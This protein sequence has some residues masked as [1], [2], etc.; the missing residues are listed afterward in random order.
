MKKLRLSLLSALWLLF[1]LALGGAADTPPPPAPA[2]ASAESPAPALPPTKDEAAAVDEGEA[3]PAAEAAPAEAPAPRPKPGKLH[4]TRDHGRQRHSGSERVS[5]FDNSTLAAGEKADVVVSV[6][7]SSTSAGEVGDAVVSVFGSSTS[8]GQVGDA[9]VS[10]LGHTRVTGGS[11]GDAAVSVLGNTYVNGHVGGEVVAVL[12]DIELGPDAVVE[13]NLVCIGG[14]VQRAPTAVVRGEVQR[15]ALGGH[16]F[17]FT[18]L[19]TWFNECLLYGRPLAFDVHLVWAWCIAFAFLGLYALVALI[20]PGGVAKCVQ[21]LEERPGRSLLAALLAMLLTPVAFLL[22]LLTLAIGIGIVLIPLFA[23]GLFFAGLFGKVVM[24]AWLGRRLTKLFGDG[25]L[26]QPFF[27]VLVGGAIMLLLYTVPVLGFVVYKLIGVLGLGV[28]VYTLLLSYQS[29]R[30]PAP[31]KPLTPPA[32][33]VPPVLGVAAGAAV[34][35]DGSAA[36][37]TAAPSVAAAAGA[38]PGWQPPVILSAATLPR[39]GFWRRLGATLLDLVL[40]GMVFGMLDGIFNWFHFGGSFPFWFAVY[41]V[42]MWTT[43]GTTV[44]GVVCGLRLVRLDDRPLDWGVS[45]IRALTAF[46]S[47]AVAGLGFIWVAFDD[48]KQ[49]WHDKVAGTVLV[50]VPKGTPLL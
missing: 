20:A 34:P 12:G 5:V 15:I 4:R 46:L 32:P 7:G 47:L 30:P 2:P 45:V 16:G 43:K 50:I 6:F 24:L 28:V 13:G 9:V 37:A 35:A 27:S 17:D 39:A 42:V 19:H 49:S 1:G 18:G 8:S 48:D 44:G 11:V 41:H 3:A 26:A 29:S 31:A 40:V 23:L 14:S 25:P 21:T 22:L 33:P 10:V 36:A 38:A